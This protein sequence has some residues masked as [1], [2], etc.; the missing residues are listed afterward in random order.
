MLSLCHFESGGLMRRRSAGAR[1]GDA[2]TAHGHHAAALWAAL[3]SDFALCAGC[4]CNWRFTGFFAP[5]LRFSEAAL[6]VPQLAR[7][8]TTSLAGASA[9][10]RAP[11][12]WF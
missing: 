4:F 12:L 9:H 6:V 7:R 2:R 1:T 3:G 11:I 5:L 10:G 8:R